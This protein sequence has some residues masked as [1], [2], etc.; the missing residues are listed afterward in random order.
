[1]GKARDLN[2]QGL[3]VNVCSLKGFF[4]VTYVSESHQVSPATG[5]AEVRVIPLL[6]GNDLCYRAAQSG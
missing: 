3:W 4:M 2:K 6:K 1:M 5:T